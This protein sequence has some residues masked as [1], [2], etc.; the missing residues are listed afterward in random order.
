MRRSNWLHAGWIMVESVGELRSGLRHLGKPV[1][2]L[3]AQ[4]CLKG[5]AKLCASVAGH[6]ERQSGGRAW[7]AAELHGLVDHD[8][9][10]RRESLLLV[11]L[12]CGGLGQPGGMPAVML[13][14]ASLAPPPRS[15][16]DGMWALLAPDSLPLL[17]ASLA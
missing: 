2:P 5:L 16:D 13:T 11:A 8:D 1:C 14:P 9:D 17:T 4:R 15:D 6:S 3:A 7:Q 12:V 10:E